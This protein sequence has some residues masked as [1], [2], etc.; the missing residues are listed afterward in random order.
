MVDYATRY[1]EAAALKDIQAETGV[2]EH[3]YKG[4][5]PKRNFE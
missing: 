3:A 1:Q 5:S 2:N 4:K